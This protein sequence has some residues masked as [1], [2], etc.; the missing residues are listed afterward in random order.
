M[1]MES[2]CCIESSLS[3][4]RVSISLA[5]LPHTSCIAQFVIYIY[6]LRILLVVMYR[7]NGELNKQSNIESR[8]TDL[9]TLHKASSV[10]FPSIQERKIELRETFS[11][12]VNGMLQFFLEWFVYILQFTVYILV[13]FCIIILGLVFVDGGQRERRA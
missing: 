6:D 11:Y 5:H 3:K 13:F 1:S 4:E 9:E 10:Q 2:G 7:V 12:F 8:L